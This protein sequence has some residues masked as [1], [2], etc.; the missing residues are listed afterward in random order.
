MLRTE[1]GLPRAVFRHLAQVEEKVLESMAW[2]SD[3]PLWEEIRANGSHLPTC[4][5]VG[6][7]TP[8]HFTWPQEL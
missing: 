3:S 7:N 8:K 4:Q 5:Q 2:T 1:A 6:N